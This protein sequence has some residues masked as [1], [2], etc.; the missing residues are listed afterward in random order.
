MNDLKEGGYC[1]YFGALLFPSG[2]PAVALQDF[3]LNKIFP[4]L[5]F[6]KTITAASV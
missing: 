5:V 6:L 3:Q 2:T 4:T 1:A